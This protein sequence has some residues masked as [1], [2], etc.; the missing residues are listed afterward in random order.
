MFKETNNRLNL[1]IFGKHPAWDDHM[2]DMGLV[3][4]SLLEF[5]RRLYLEGVSGRLDMGAWREMKPENRMEA[6]DHEL[7]WSGETGVIFAVLWHSSD[8]RGRSSYPMVAAAHFLTNKLPAKVAPIFQA[9]QKV[10]ES[11]R[12]SGSRDGIYQAQAEGMEGLM[13][14]ARSLVPISAGSWDVRDRE[15]F[16]DSV[17]RFGDN[18]E[19][20]MRV[21][22]ALR[23]DDGE[24]ERAPQKSLSLRVAA[25]RENPEDLLAWQVLM[26]AQ[27]G[28]ELPLLTMRHREK[29]WLDVL[30]GEF[31]SPEFVRLKADSGEIPLTSS[32]PYDVSEELREKANMVLDSF[33]TD[34]ERIPKV[35]GCGGDGAGQGL[36][37]SLL[38]RFFRS[39]PN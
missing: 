14:A 33:V 6:F 5:K 1:A 10:A 2:E 29:E 21:F 32:I 24:E 26:R 38:S 13:Q 18:R 30:I 8:G 19:G 11:C 37:G 20:L 4:P 31:D 16:V 12:R 39:A 17:A 23:P 15:A 7:I 34:P 35:D 3:S 28:P 22:Y 25:E 9:L 27:C 36:L